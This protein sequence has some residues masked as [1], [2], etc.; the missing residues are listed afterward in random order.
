MDKLVALL[1]ALVL[2][3]RGRRREAL[4][5]VLADLREE[6]GKRQAVELDELNECRRTVEDLASANAIL[7]GE[8]TLLRDN[9][10][11]SESRH[12][13]LMRSCAELRK[14]MEDAEEDARKATRELIEVQD[15]AAKDRKDL[16]YFRGEAVNLNQERDHLMTEIGRYKAGLASLQQE[17]D[18]LQ[19]ERR[20]ANDHEVRLAK[21][22]Q[23][24]REESTWLR[25][26]V[27]TLQ[28]VVNV[29]RDEEWRRITGGES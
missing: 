9:L 19:A 7:N 3:L 12:F 21:D 25:A 27:N 17:R 18:A 28:T 15:T 16:D 10:R 24:E 23:A 14:R 22:L 2:G 11:Q 26:A 20:A 29:L 6:S 4:E 13:D 8:A 5:Q 1:E